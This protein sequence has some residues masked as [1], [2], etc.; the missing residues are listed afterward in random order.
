MAIKQKKKTV[1]F[2]YI[3]NFVAVA[4]I[5]LFLNIGSVHIGSFAKYLAKKKRFALGKFCRGT[6]TDPDVPQHGP[7]ARLAGLMGR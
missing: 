3:K 1:D 7:V 2:G 4:K 5:T 6:S